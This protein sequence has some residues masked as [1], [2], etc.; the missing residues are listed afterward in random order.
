MERNRWNK[1]WI[2]D[3]LD[4]GDERTDLKKRLYEAERAKAYK[5]ANMGIQKAVKAKED[6]LGE[7]IETCLET[8]RQHISLFRETGW[9]R[10]LNVSQKN[11]IFSVDG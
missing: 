11:K 7:E 6:W 4:L 5:E 8:A 1:P 3:V 2:T 10:M 9:T